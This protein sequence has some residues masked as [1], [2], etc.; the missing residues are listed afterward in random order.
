MP[1]LTYTRH[2]KK[3]NHRD[4]G[5]GAEMNGETILKAQGSVLEGEIVSEVTDG[6]GVTRVCTYLIPLIYTLA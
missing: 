1:D 6:D 4:S 3:L 2:P 5:L